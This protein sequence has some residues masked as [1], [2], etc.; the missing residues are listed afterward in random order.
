MRVI[1][2]AGIAGDLR[3]F[4]VFASR[5]EVQIVHGDEDSPLAGFKPV[6]DIGQSPVHDRAHRVREITVLKFLL[7]LEIL[8]PIGRRRR[9]Y[10]C[11]SES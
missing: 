4:Q 5:P 6:A 1:V 7:D 2:A 9:C 10:F 3:A 8:N 11:H